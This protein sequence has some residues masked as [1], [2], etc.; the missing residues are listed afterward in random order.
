MDT[1]ALVE[2]RVKLFEDNKVLLDKAAEEKRTL[3]TDEQQ[4]FD[5]REA[6]LGEIRGTLDRAALQEAEER[7]L[8]ESRGRKTETKVKGVEVSNTRAQDEDLAFRAWAMGEQATPEM[9]AAAERIGMRYQRRELETRALSVGVTTGG[10]NSVVNEMN[11][12]FWEV[13]KWFGP[14]RQV[15]TTI[16]TSTGAPLPIPNA[17]DTA[18]VGEIIAEAGAVTTTADP[19]FNTL[20]LGAFKYSSK[21]VIVS[22][23]LLQDSIIPLPEY[24]GRRLGERIGRIQNTHFTVGAGTTLPFGLATQAALG[25]T[26]AATNAITFDEMIDLMVSVDPAYR[27]APG[28]KL[29]MHD[30]TAAMLRK[31]KDSQNRYI[32]EMSVQSG[33]PDRIYGIPVVINNDM[34]Q[35]TATAKRVVLFGDLSNYLIRDTSD[36]IFI[37]SDELRVLNHQTVF[38][39]FQRSDGNLPNVNSVKYLRTL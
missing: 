26:A 35:P 24:L 10:G 15:A 17:D 7:A 5:R 30:A 25:K 12:A 18:N 20:T 37:R 39:A 36:V 3:K 16:R 11:R 22:V 31:V 32:W 23:E 8:S 38:L 9:V 2:E 6:R 14:M 27:Y 33:A 21:A 29:M 28:S 19:L 13:E 34:D 4:E 1:K